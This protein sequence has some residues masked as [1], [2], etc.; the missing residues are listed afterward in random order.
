MK[1]KIINKKKKIFQRF[2]NQRIDCYNWI[3]DKK[4]PD[5]NNYAILNCVNNEN[6][7]VNSKLIKCF[8]LS[9]IIYQEMKNSIN[10]D[11]KT[12][13][14]KMHYYH[15]YSYIKKNMNYCVYLRKYQSLLSK[16]EAILDENKLSKGYYYCEIRGVSVSPRHDFLSYSIDYKGNERYDIKV[17]NLIQKKILNDTVVNTFGIIIWHKNNKG[18]FY[19]PAGKN[20]RA[21]QV[22]YHEIGLN[23]QNDILLYKENNLIFNVDI[24]KSASKK[25]LIITTSN[26]E[27]NES[28]FVDLAKSHFNLQIFD[29]RIKQYKYTVNNYKNKFFILTNN[30]GRNF[31]ISI[32]KQN[33]L[34]KNWIDFIPCSSDNYIHDFD[35]F[36]NNIIIT[37]SSN[38]SGL[39]S[40]EFIN[41]INYSSKKL[42]FFDKCY[43]VNV[44]Y[45]TYHAQS[46]RYGYSSLSTPSIIKAFNFIDNQ[47]SILKINKIPFRFKPKKYQVK[48]LYSYSRNRK[49]IPIS[50]IYKNGKCKINKN[51]PVYLYGYGS[52]GISIPLSFKKNIYSLINRG[53]IYA[54]CHIRGGDD[55]GHKWHKYGK[56]FYKKNTFYDYID[57]VHFLIKNKYVNYPHVVISGGSA[58]G[59]LMGF[60]AN[61]KPELFKI[62]IAQVPFVDVL[63]T[64]LDKNLP[65]TPGEYKEWGNPKKKDFYFYIKSYCPYQNLKKQRY[66]NFFITAGLNDPRVTYWEPVKWVAK[67]RDCK[68]DNSL[69]LLKINMNEGHSGKSERYEYLKEISQE[70]SFIIKRMIDFLI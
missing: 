50:L 51:N 36:A 11:D 24:V 42:N 52:Y 60:C 13:S 18:F 64:M 69:I 70:Y 33:N 58:G 5:V 12:V 66:P 35:L 10:E 67:L 68:I 7:Y 43:Q 40:L 57:I 46:F 55:L 15:Y 39:L 54:I 34:K 8:N 22:F 9:H 3:R 6:Y 59:L 26:S 28:Y 62:V 17:K 45:T 47:N 48:R 53:F 2:E 65:L 27:E 1:V 38:K 23:Y 49:K 61:H 29:I 37:S 56:F 19:I 16:E 14:V 4:Y 44:L 30:K 63:N 20:W 41:L 31:G 25:Y 21:S 32:I